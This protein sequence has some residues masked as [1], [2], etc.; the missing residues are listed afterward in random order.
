MGWLLE[1]EG[2]DDELVSAAIGEHID[3]AGLLSDVPLVTQTSTPSGRYGT[4]RSWHAHQLW[5]RHLP[6]DRPKEARSAGVRRVAAVLIER[7]DYGRAFRLLARTG[8][9]AGQLD[10]LANATAG[11]EPSVPLAE[12][13]AWMEIASPESLVHPVVTYTKGLVAQVRDPAGAIRFM[14]AAAEG[15]RRLGDRASE[16]RAITQIARLVHW[17]GDLTAAG[18][19]LKRLVELDR[20]GI[21][22][23]DR[24]V[25]LATSL[26]A[27]AGGDDVSSL[28]IM[29]SLPPGW[30]GTDIE[31][32]AL[33]QQITASLWLGRVDE[34]MRFVV[35]AEEHA[36]PSVQRLV[37]DAR[38]RAEWAAGVTHSA[39]RADRRNDASDEETDLHHRTAHLFFRRSRDA[40]FSGDS[41]QAEHFRTLAAVHQRTE[42]IDPLHNDVALALVSLAAGDEVGASDALRRAIGSRSLDETELR[43]SFGLIPAI[44]YVLLPETRDWW[45]AREIALVD[46]LGPRFTLSLAAARTLLRIRSHERLRA[47]DAHLAAEMMSTLVPIAWSM[48]I[49]ASMHAAGLVD[50]SRTLVKARGA[51]ARPWLE[52]LLRSPDRAIGAAARRLL[53][54]VPNGPTTPV[55]IN[56][57]GSA[58]VRRGS[59]DLIA[60]E[61][62]DVD[63]FELLGFLATQP[64]TDRRSLGPRLWPLQPQSSVARRLDAA[65]RA[66]DALLEPGR[67]KGFTTQ[68]LRVA[69]GS[70]RLVRSEYLE[71]DVWRFQSLID[72]AYN[73][74]SRHLPSEALE[75]F[76][77]GIALVNGPFM[78]ERTGPEWLESTRKAFRDLAVS[79]ALRASEICIAGRLPDASMFAEWAVAFDPRRRLPVVAH[80]A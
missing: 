80:I 66:L 56:L 47:A 26:V 23:A 31:V 62:S 6:D 57:F 16:V 17:T 51:S 20:C 60:M 12:L 79:A 29:S 59:A 48:E 9:S 77:A 4:L 37:A 49:A 7:C 65:L 55:T 40:A 13:A 33:Y 67:P 32:M 38:A 22:G 54:E 73:S 50:P 44:P 42:T 2:G 74:L 36:R 78:F 25:G 46:V 14:T 76:H 19:A 58:S 39:N 43:R 61:F 71:V 1:L 45:D 69:A 52:R 41:Q 28:R 34:A 70:V 5:M 24:L 21:A 72:D 53:A 10:V 63:A 8:D 68:H 30:A 75:H 11:L 35:Q 15:F 3:L 64:Q 27:Y 18:G